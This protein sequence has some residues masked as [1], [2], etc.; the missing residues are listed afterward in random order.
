M[1]VTIDNSIF[2]DNYMNVAFLCLGGNIG[3]R[4]LALQT[5]IEQIELK[6]G[7]ILQKSSIYE[8]EGWG[9]ENHKPYLNQCIVITTTLTSEALLKQLL[10][11]EKELGRIRNTTH[12][13]EPRNIDIDILLFNDDIIE[14]NELIVPHPRLHLRKFVLIP[15][16]EIAPKMIHPLLHKNITELLNECN[17]TGSVLKY[18]S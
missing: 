6:V 18:N 5:A 1:Q 16:A 7:A 10:L 9:V 8:T 14:T 4:T 17:D 12:T 3:N 11:I 2:T 15:L 13:Y